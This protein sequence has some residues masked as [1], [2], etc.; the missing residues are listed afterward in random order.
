M[1]YTFV[2]TMFFL[3][4]VYLSPCE[5]NLLLSFW[6]RR[7]KKRLCLIVAVTNCWSSQS[8][9]SHQP[10][11]ELACCTKCMAVR[12]GYKTVFKLL[13]TSLRASNYVPLEFEFHLQFPCG[14]LLTELLNFCQ[15]AWS[16]NENKCKQTLKTHAKG[17]DVITNVISA[18]QHFTSTFLMQMLKFQRCS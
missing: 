7:K 17:N 16:R 14:S 13:A 10:G 2:G 12:F 11:D 9:F 8:C 5:Q 1:V 4:G 15:S 3:S 6:V 18:N